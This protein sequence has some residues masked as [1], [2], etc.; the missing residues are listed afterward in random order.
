[1]TFSR[2]GFLGTLLGAVSTAIV[3]PKLELPAPRS[4]ALP[5]ASVARKFFLPPQGGWSLPYLNEVVQAELVPYM[6]GAYETTYEVEGWYYP[7]N[8]HMAVGDRR[9][10]TSTKGERRI[11]EV[12]EVHLSV[13]Q[14]NMASIRYIFRD[15]EGLSAIPLTGN[16]FPGVNVYNWQANQR[17]DRYD[18]TD[19][20]APQ[21]VQM[22]PYISRTGKMTGR[23]V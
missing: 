3:V 8:N 14:D 21:K 5:S 2:R 11:V 7:I 1:M 23:R 22:S 4:I 6:Q 9:V 20:G 18:V 19:F 13:P 12:D 17:L 15:I 10:I 16:N